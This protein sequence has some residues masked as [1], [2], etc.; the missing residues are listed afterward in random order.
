MVGSVPG[1]ITYLDYSH[2]GLAS[3]CLGLLVLGLCEKK[4]KN[5]KIKE[6]NEKRKDF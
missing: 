3:L 4:D 2:D 6:M 1:T 5:D